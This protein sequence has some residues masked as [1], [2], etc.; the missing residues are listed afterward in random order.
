MG[1]TP[2]SAKAAPVGTRGLH[3]QRAAD[4]WMGR[5]GQ[6]APFLPLLPSTTTCGS[7]SDRGPALTKLLVSWGSV[8]QHSVSYSTSEKRQVG[9]GLREV[10]EGSPW[11]A[12]AAKLAYEQ[13]PA[14]SVFQADGVASAKVLGQ[15]PAWVPGRA[16]RL[17]GP[18]G[19]GRKEEGTHCIHLQ[20][21]LC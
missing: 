18:E 2:A 17:E 20:D 13:R 12:V 3:Q 4:G 16:W 19:E 15:E 10:L 21:L 8:T 1:L 6:G 14:G 11:E 9:V 5:E 7:F